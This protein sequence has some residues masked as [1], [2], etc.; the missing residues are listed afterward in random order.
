MKQCAEILAI[1]PDS[2]AEELELEVGDVIAKINDKNI[3]DLIQFQ[4]EWAGEEVSLEIEKKTGE[5]EIYEIEKDYDEPLGV[6][7]NQ[8]VF[9]GL[10]YCQN[11]CLFCF[12]DQMA[13]NMRKTLYVKDDDYRLSF[14]QGN[15]ITLT[16]LRESEIERIK[17]EHLSPLYVSVHTTNGE[18][19]KKLLNNP[20]A[21]KILDILKELSAA[22]IKIHT[23]V[24]LCPGINDGEY[25]EQT[26][27]DLKDIEGIQSLA[28]VPVGLTK[29]RKNLAVIKTYTKETAL[30]IIEWAEKRQQA[31]RATKNTSFLWLSDEFYQLADKK[32]PPYEIYEDF[33]QLENGVGMVRLLWDDFAH[34]NLPEEIKPA[35]EF[36]I[37]TGA[38]GRYA[39]QPIVKRLNE[40]KGLQVELKVVQNIFFGST[41]TVTGLLTG[42]CLLEG[43]KDAK[44]GSKVLIPSV[45]LKTHENKFLDD[46]T[47]AEVEDALGKNIKIIHAEST[48]KDIIDK[49]RSN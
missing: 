35:K 42:G 43:L 26:Y 38:S 46:L 9:D 45:M 14:L 30:E 2:L 7:F 15:F 39:L 19:R 20:K 34:Y 24:V 44:E 49:I 22:G 27:L 25:L 17:K 18:L 37:M 5:K 48:A 1:N 10:K 33:P 29:F 32:V 36:I 40:I 3:T 12:V 21:G 16:N 13:P 23:Q 41:V 11:K 28:V 31:C 8:A 47:I 4:F 6:V